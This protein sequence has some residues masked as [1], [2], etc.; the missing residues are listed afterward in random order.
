MKWALMPIPWRAK[1]L[2]F[3]QQRRV[4]LEGHFKGIKG[5]EVC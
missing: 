5:V 4:I 1:N 2:D 3:G